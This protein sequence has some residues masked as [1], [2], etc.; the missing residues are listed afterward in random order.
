M[1]RAM[2]CNDTP[3][4]PR[5]VQRKR[6]KGRDYYYFRW[7]DVYRRLP[8]NPNS[9][10]FRIDYAKALASIAPERE[11]AIIAGSVRAL[12]RDYKESPEWNALA[13]KTQADYARVLDHLRPI[14]D[15]QA[16]NVRRQHVISLRNKIGSNTR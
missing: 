6:V 12:I 3:P 11:H 5:F 15:F 10:G 7:Q 13:P 9:E 2:Q 14:G 4:L 1:G 16:D 8:D